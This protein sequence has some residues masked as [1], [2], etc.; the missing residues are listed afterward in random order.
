MTVPRN[1]LWVVTHSSSS[2]IFWWVLTQSIYCWSDFLRVSMDGRFVY[3]YVHMRMRDMWNYCQ[4]NSRIKWELGFVG[5]AL[6]QL[7]YLMALTLLSSWPN[8][9]VFCFVLQAFGGERWVYHDCSPTLPR[10]K[11]IRMSLLI[12]PLCM[13]GAMIS[14]YVWR[15]IGWAML[16][17]VFENIGNI[18]PSIMVYGALCWTV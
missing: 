18:Y 7:H 1:R 2:A 9:R 16:F 17:F 14:L 3:A 4:N 8:S 10:K 13:W 12:E 15:G 5:A 11:I 6:K